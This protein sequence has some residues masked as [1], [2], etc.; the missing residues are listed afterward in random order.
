MKPLLTLALAL[1]TLTPAFAQPTQIAPPM[2]NISG[3]AE[4]KVAPDEIYLRLGVETRD[5]NLEVA[6][7][8]ND[9]RISKALAFLKTSQ[10]NSKDI[11]TDYLSIE[12][13]YNNNSSS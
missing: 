13:N 4:V 11:Q 9:E 12:P 5:E 8:Q 7:K 6:K 10:I 3:S 2:I 1:F